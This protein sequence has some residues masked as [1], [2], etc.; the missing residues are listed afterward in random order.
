[1]KKIKLTRRNFLKWSLRCSVC[2]VL[3]YPTL[4]EPNWLAFK[5]V[6]VPIQGLPKSFN[7]LKIGLLADFHRG[8]FVQESMIDKAVGIMQRAKPDLVLLVGDFVEGKAEY[9][10]SVAQVLS[11]LVV[12]LGM[13]AVLGNHDYWT[14]PV[15]IKDILERYKI[16][17]LINR[18]VEITTKGNS[19]FVAGLDDAWEGQPDCKKAL[20]DIPEDKMV[21]LMVHEPDYADTITQSNKWIPLQLSGHSHGGQVVVPFFGAP[22]LPYMAKKYPSGLYR[23]GSSNRFVYTTNG[24]GSVLPFRLNCRPEVSLLTLRRFN[25]STLS[26]LDGF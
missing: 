10:E 5:K 2:A 24:I 17:T 25:G 3:G 26:F 22:V 9:I 20:R 15:L 19:F 23:I 14:D 21:L 11:K 8:L 6:E 18:A 1:M 16:P 13:Y 12:P 4:V 7:R